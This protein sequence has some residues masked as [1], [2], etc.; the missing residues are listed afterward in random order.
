[1]TGAE[2]QKMI[3]A[4][5]LTQVDSATMLGVNGRTVRRW[6]ADDVPIPAS[7]AIVLRL[8]KKYKIDPDTINKVGEA[9]RVTPD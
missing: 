9:D 3:D 4:F 2:Y 6:V 1:M 7:A 8:M 5:G